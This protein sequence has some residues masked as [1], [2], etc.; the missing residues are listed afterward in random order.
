MIAAQRVGDTFWRV[1]STSPQWKTLVGPGVVDQFGRD[2]LNQ[3]FV[4]AHKN[5]NISEPLQTG[6]GRFQCV[7]IPNSYFSEQS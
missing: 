6:R 7:L 4:L 2:W 1:L 5:G 3:G